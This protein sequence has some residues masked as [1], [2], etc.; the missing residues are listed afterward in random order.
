MSISCGHCKGR[1][2][3]VAGVRECGLG[4]VLATDNPPPRLPAQV[5]NLITEG[6]WTTEDG[7]RIFKVQIAHHGSGQL[8]TKELVEEKFSDD[9]PSVWEFQMFRG[10]MT[11]LRKTAGIRQMSL[12]EAMEFGRLYGICCKCGRVLTNEESIALG[13]GPICRG[14]FIV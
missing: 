6:M 7:K 1:H 9:V 8:Y 10:G 3:T 4:V 11:F 2:N 13:I 5:H 12:E 14:A